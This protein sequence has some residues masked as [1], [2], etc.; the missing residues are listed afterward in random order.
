MAAVHQAPSP[1]AVPQAQTAALKANT[2]SPKAV[3]VAVQA[4]PAMHL[5]RIAVKVLHAIQMERSAV[6]MDDIVR[7]EVYV[8]FMREL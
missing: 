2:A 3:P 5:R 6:L 8:C 4:V 1:N 7:L